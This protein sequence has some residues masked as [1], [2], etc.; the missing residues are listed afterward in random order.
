MFVNKQLLRTHQ[1][2]A[3]KKQINLQICVWVFIFIYCETLLSYF[4]FKSG[5]F[6]FHNSYLYSI[7]IIIKLSIIN[8]KDK[9]F[10]ILTQHEIIIL[11]VSINI[12]I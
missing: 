2:T 9:L 11:F 5:D 1:P 3:C 6:S 4:N 7:Q 12:I 8:I 10:F